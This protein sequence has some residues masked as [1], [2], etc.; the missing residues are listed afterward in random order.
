MNKTT[1]KTSTETQLAASKVAAGIKKP[2]QTKEQTKLIEQGIQKGIEQYKKAQKIKAREADKAKKKQQ[3]Q[4]QINTV[5]QLLT[6]DEENGIAKARHNFLP[7]VLLVLSWL[8]FGLFY[9]SFI[10]K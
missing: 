3:K 4:R 7:W 5:E 10:N 6:S 2:G 9:F 8:S 1:N